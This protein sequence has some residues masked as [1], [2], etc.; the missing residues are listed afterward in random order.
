MKKLS[1]KNQYFLGVAII[2]LICCAGAS[3]YQCQN[4]LH[5]ALT[6]V[7]KIIEKYLATAA[8]IRTYAKDVLRPKVSGLVTSGPLLL[9]AMPT[10]CMSH[11]KSNQDPDIDRIFAT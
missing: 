7:N 5:Q 1:L 3:W 9:E 4:L 6:S 11:Q 10:S 2:L 8:A